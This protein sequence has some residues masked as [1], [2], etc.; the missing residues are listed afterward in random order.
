MFSFIGYKSIEE[1]VVL[2]SNLK[3]SHELEYAKTEIKPVVI[4]ADNLPSTLSA[5]TMSCLKL[6]PKELAQLPGFVGDLDIIKSLQSVPGIKT[7]GD[8]SSLFYVRGGNSDQNLILVDEAPI[9]NP[10]HLF[11]FFSALAPDAINDAEVFKGDFPA[12][13]GGRLSSVIDIKIKEGNMK[14]F[15]FG[16]SVGPILPICRSKRP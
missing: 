6:S 3:I 4:S 11:G 14:K 16:G 12:K 15:G 13:Y 7:Y 5:S 10:S 2:N 9:Y 8:G 1:D